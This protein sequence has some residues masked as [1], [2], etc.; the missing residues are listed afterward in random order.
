VR[1]R[2]MSSHGALVE[3]ATL[4]PIGSQVRLCRGSLCVA[5][6][7]MWVDDGKAG[8]HFS[9]VTALK[10]WMPGGKRYTGQQMADEMAHQA[11]LG[12]IPKMGSAAALDAAP[13]TIGDLLIPLRE[14]LEQ[15]GEELA[16]DVEVATRH[17]GPLQTIDGVCQSLARFTESA[18]P[19]AGIVPVRGAAG[20]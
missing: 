17:A 11:R 19:V 9:S 13:S 7:V 16:A 14:Q 15:A 5:G 1:I 8:L 12:V 3:A 20:P 2:N 6:E 18:G 10:D 4:P